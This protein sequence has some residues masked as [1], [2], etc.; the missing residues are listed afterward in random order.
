MKTTV[1]ISL[2]LLEQA[3]KLA[4]QEGTT[5]KA[6][7]ERGLREQLA[8]RKRTQVF[9]LRKTSYKGKGLQAEAKGVGWDKLRDLAYEGRGG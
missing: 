1:E 3:K 9:R 4:A 5:I 7:I 8:K 2:P 6:L